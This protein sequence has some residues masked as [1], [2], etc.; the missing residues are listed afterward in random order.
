MIM[1]VD[2]TRVNTQTMVSATEGMVA[3]VNSHTE[4]V[5]VGVWETEERKGKE[6][7]VGTAIVGI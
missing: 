1:V 2:V 6:E 7:D 4:G 5:V 3:T